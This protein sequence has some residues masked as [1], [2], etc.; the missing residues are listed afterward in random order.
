MSEEIVHRVQTLPPEELARAGFYGLFGR[1]FFGP[2]DAALL[3]VLAG[4]E[5][6]TAGDADLRDTWE[7]L[8]NAAG[9]ADVET[10]REA[11]D[12]AFIGTGKSPVSLYTTAYTLR[13]ASE[14]PLVALRADLAELGLG[15]HPSSHEPEDHIAALCDVMRHLVATEERAV[16]RQARFFNRWIAPPAQPLC[17]AIA[18]HL[19]G[20]FYE[21]VAR[22][23]QAFF[24]VE[25]SA[26]DLFDVATSRRSG[27][28]EAPNAHITGQERR[29]S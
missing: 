25:R 13:S 6:M 5:G 19:R 21:H 23:A 3:E 17:A 1:L 11:Y 27:S 28:P 10:L 4:A 16:S 12:T 8:I 15:R 20:T 18:E 7:A 2:P 29:A 9:H 22:L 26:F 24:Q 14:V